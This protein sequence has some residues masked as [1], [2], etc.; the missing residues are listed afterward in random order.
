MRVGQQNV[1]SIMSD[2]DWICESDAG[3]ARVPDDCETV[4]EMD[5][6]N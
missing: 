5:D 4:T 1:V 6:E 2:D 3:Q